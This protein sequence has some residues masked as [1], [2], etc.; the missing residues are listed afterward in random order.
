MSNS[1]ILISKFVKSK[2]TSNFR[3]NSFMTEVPIIIGN[4]VMNELNTSGFKSQNGLIL[5]NVSELFKIPIYIQKQPSK[6][7]FRKT[8]G[9]LLLFVG[10][11]FINSI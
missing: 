7:V 1:A 10:N 5:R 9:R 6:G 2:L 11:Y 8:F 3:F 4:F